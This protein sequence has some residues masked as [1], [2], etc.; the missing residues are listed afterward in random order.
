MGISW[1]LKLLDQDE[2]VTGRPS[3]NAKAFLL[4]SDG[5][6]WSGEVDRALLGGAKRHH[7][8]LARAAAQRVA[9]PAP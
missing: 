2:R 9:V 6:A 5:Q 7:A 3:L 1:A 4:L 8:A